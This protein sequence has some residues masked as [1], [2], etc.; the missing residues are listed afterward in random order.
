MDTPMQT[1]G[2]K[3]YSDVTIQVAAESLERAAARSDLT[4]FEVDQLTGIVTV[5]RALAS[6]VNA[7]ESAY[8]KKIG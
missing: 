6:Q 7:R 2:R 3:A 4:S 5:L 1:R 8:G